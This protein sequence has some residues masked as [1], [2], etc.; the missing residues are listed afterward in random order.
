M[1]EGKQNSKS[2]ISRIDV[3]SRSWKTFLT[4][5]AALLMFAGPTYVPYMLI[6]ALN[7]DYFLSM[8]VGIFLLIAGLVLTWYLIKKKAIS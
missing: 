5:V 6:R 1:A 2:R 7:V 8:V 4:V 3:S